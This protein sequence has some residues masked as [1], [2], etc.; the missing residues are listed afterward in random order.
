[1]SVL[2]TGGISSSTH[3]VW[4]FIMLILSTSLLRLWATKLPAVTILMQ[5]PFTVQYLSKIVLLQK[6]GFHA[7]QSLIGVWVLPRDPMQSLV[8][9]LDDLNNS[10]NP[11]DC[12]ITIPC[13]AVTYCMVL[14]LNDWSRR[15]YLVIWACS[16]SFLLLL[17][18]L[19]HTA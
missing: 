3:L 4:P 16:F 17:D 5:F 15:K 8:S 2:T 14:C 18:S 12:R 19:Q 6:D 7:I 11:F 13:H 10:S 1:M 9:E